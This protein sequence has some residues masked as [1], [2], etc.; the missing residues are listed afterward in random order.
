MN[1]RFKGKCVRCERWFPEGEV[2]FWNGERKEARHANCEYAAWEHE[3]R[4][5]QRAEAK[6]KE[7]FLKL[8]D[9][10]AA[11]KGA[12]TRRAVIERASAMELT[13][14]QRLQLLIEA[15]RLD[16]EQAVEK[17]EG[18]KSAVVK[19][20]RLKEALAAIRADDVPDEL[21]AGQIELLE[22]ALAA[23]GEEPEG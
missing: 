1:A 9:R 18:L 8:L 12:A 22:E 17:V 15:S 21:Q 7:S 6:R 2:I 3:M 19:R 4:V 23:L 10:V 13:A 20:R 11:S 5:F 14:D 16:A